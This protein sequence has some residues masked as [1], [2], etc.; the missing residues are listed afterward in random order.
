MVR[1]VGAKREGQ[2]VVSEPGLV[3]NIAMDCS[4]HLR[5]LGVEDI[6]PVMIILMKVL[7]VLISIGR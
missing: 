1:A 2:G 3:Q 6:V 7:L 4:G 5:T